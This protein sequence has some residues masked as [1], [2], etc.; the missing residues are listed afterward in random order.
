[1][2][3]ATHQTWRKQLPNIVLKLCHAIETAGGQ[4]W[5]VGGVVRDLCL[6]IPPKDMD[7]EVYGLEPDALQ[8]L[9]QQFGRIEILGKHFGVLKL[10][11]QGIDID[12][13]LP[14]TEI[15]T[16]AGHRGFTVSPDPYISPET[17]TLRRDFTI[18]A[19]MYDPLN[20]NLLDLHH[21]QEDLKKHILRHVSP[22]FAEDP[23]RVLRAM[24]FAA[25][26]NLKLHPETA[27][28]C[29]KLL[30]EAAKLP[31]SRIWCEWQK[32]LHAPFPS[33]G[34]S[35]LKES[36]WLSL[37]PELEALIDCPQD[38]YWHPEGD[39]WKHTL[40]VCDQAAQIS[41]RQSLSTQQREYLIL[42]ALCHDLGKPSTTIT[43]SNGGI[44]S[45]NH[46]QAGLA[47]SLS[48]L[49]RIAAPKR[50]AIFVQPLVYD[51]IT[52][53]SGEPTSRAV[54]RLAHRLEPA[55][56]E[57]WEMLAEADGSGRSPAPAARPALSWLEKA[58]ELATH[59]QKTAAIVDGKLLLEMGVNAGKEMGACIKD[60]YQAQL[61][62]TFNDITS[63]KKWLKRY[64]KTMKQRNNSSQ[65]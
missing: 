45:P 15:K 37:Y 38:A 56:I 51:H 5:L 3:N 25:R 13:A 4:A 49:Q 46:S 11:T 19:M 12:L 21:G 27:Q 55:C 40:Q 16:S 57:L 30:P 63:A 58:R 24:Q 61:D 50:M 2:T 22:A 43:G 7:I 54:R 14:R 41:V 53:L 44:H 60:A 59:Q 48:F 6:A 29:R 20:G 39:V 17:A 33:K 10:W 8:N 52:H 34:L 26:F 32:W 64:L 1:M 35:A 65:L 47:P 9:A 62:G 42:A 18:N 23:L 36:H 28:L 31:T